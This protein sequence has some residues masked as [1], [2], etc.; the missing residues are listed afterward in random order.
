MT[1]L[2]QSPALAERR[3]PA[4]TN[5][6]GCLVLRDA[7]GTPLLVA[8]YTRDL[9]WIYRG[10][11]TGSLDLAALMAEPPGGL[12]HGWHRRHLPSPE[13]QQLDVEHEDANVPRPTSPQAEKARIWARLDQAV[14]RDYLA[15]GGWH[16]EHAGSTGNSPGRP[17]RGMRNRDRLVVELCERCG[18]AEPAEL[19]RALGK[20]ADP[21][22]RAR[23]A[24]A[25]KEGTNRRERPWNVA[26]VARLLGVSRKTIYTL[27]RL[28]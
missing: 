18:V 26:A 13:R 4:W 1:A 23:L 19:A 28:R 2:H 25:V 17:A 6:G 3:A 9:G 11:H 24:A 8:V 14:A 5:E 16:A 10:P 22:L 20:G 15:E 7:S 12:N 27:I 21:A